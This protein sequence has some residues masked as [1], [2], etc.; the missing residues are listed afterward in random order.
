MKNNSLAFVSH[1][2]MIGE[3]IQDLKT[4]T[5]NVKNLYQHLM[6]ERG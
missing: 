5:V 4:L 1:F 2:L 6:R 3:Q